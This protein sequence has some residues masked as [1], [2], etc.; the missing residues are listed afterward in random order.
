MLKYSGVRYLAHVASLADEILTRV[1]DDSSSVLTA[2]EH[3][4]VIS[5]LATVSFSTEERTLQEW[6]D[7]DGLDFVG[8]AHPGRP[9]ERLLASTVLTSLE[10]HTL[11]HTLADQS[12][13]LATSPAEYL[14]NMRRACRHP[15]AVLHVGR[16]RYM[17][18]LGRAPSLAIIRLDV[19]AAPTLPNVRRGAGLELFVVY[20]RGKSKLVSAYVMSSEQVNSELATW[21]NQRRL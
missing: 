4:I 16:G 5:H 17:R 3:E 13:C 6:Q 2:R 7:K 19:C 15:A 8:E 11:K 9:G 1:I 10:Y 21:S 12:F 20:D 14:D 18:R